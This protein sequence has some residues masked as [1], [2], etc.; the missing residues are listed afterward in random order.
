RFG[1]NIRIETQENAG[2]TAIVQL[3]VR[4]GGARLAD[5]SAELLK[6]PRWHE[7]E[8]MIRL[9]MDGKAGEAL[10][11]VDEV[12]LKLPDQPL[13][14]EHIGHKQIIQLFKLTLLA[15]ENSQQAD[16]QRR[17]HASAQLWKHHESELKRGKD[18][19][20]SH[21]DLENFMR[22]R[23]EFAWQNIGVSGQN[24]IPS[25]PVPLRQ[26]SAKPN[27]PR[28]AVTAPRPSVHEET[29][30][31]EKFQRDMT[32]LDEATRNGRMEEMIRI[33]GIYWP[34]VET[35]KH[36]DERYLKILRAARKAVDSGA[37]LSE[38]A[39]PYS[40]Q[41]GSLAN[42]EVKV[43]VAR[44]YDVKRQ[45]GKI[46]IGPV[47]LD[48]AFDQTTSEL[49]ITGL[50]EQP[51][52]VD[53]IRERNPNGDTPIDG[54]YE[55]RFNA[56]DLKLVLEKASHA[57]DGVFTHSNQKTRTVIEL[58]LSLFDAVESLSED[59]IRTIAR[60]MYIAYFNR[61][62]GLTNL[63]L[64]KPGRDPLLAKRIG[65]I[66]KAIDAS[67]V[68]VFSEQEI[69]V[70]FREVSRVVITGASTAPEPGKRYLLTQ[71]FRMGDIGNYR[72]IFEAA[73]YL[74][75]IP[76]ANLVAGDKLVDP[77]VNAHR[78]LTGG[79]AEEPAVLIRVWKGGEPDALVRSRFEI[80]PIIRLAVNH[81]LRG[82]RLA[83][84]MAEQSS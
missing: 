70:D 23:R 51:I 44:V 5:S 4:A 25:A 56:A 11:F 10:S 29:S 28:E 77:M 37:R 45:V 35:G 32:A 52:R 1:G 75:R 83:R 3:P 49:I 6:D 21:R 69:P 18:S 26:G 7:L 79:K 59:E 73:S 76:D 19:G 38:S 43:F 62:Y 82:A 60:E 14:N 2:T 74:G 65:E 40:F 78:I 64:L 71:P 30:S 46:A 57:L 8:L 47:I 58:D 16:I 36:F 39:L 22:W 50:G 61:V 81:I 33:L 27:Q 66:L 31:K 34:R 80:P 12:L 54:E 15:V 55:L 63:F 84:Q 48:V 72:G 9:A 17:F 13:P 24:L 42:E 20:I 53:Y 67:A 41:K 68:A